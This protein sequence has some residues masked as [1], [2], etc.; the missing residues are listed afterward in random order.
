MPSPESPGEADD[1]LVNTSLLVF[2]EG[3]SINVDMLARYPRTADCS[4]WS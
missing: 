4:S 3:I 1:R 2:P